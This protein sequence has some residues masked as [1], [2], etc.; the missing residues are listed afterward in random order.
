MSFNSNDSRF[1]A[2]AIQL[3]HRGWFTTRTNP[4]VGCVLVKDISDNDDDDMS[5]GFML[6][7]LAGALLSLLLFAP[8]KKFKS[9][10]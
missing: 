8:T 10:V 6:S 2:R 3:A 1:M 4:R 9:F 7:I 5:G